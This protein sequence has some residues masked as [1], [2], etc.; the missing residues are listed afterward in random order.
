[1]Q[2]FNFNPVNM[3]DSRIV[4]SSVHFMTILPVVHYPF[5]ILFHIPSAS[6]VATSKRTTEHSKTSAAE[7]MMQGIRF[8]LKYGLSL[9]FFEETNFK[10]KN[11]YSYL[12]MG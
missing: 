1:M 9:Y 4:P 5:V 3:D 2:L 7:V 11:T 12:A 6:H 8:S 10:S